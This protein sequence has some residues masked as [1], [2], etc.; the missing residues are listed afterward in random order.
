MAKEGATI[1][2]NFLH[3]TLE[4]GIDVGCQISVVIEIILKEKPIGINKHSPTY[5]RHS[6]VEE[7]YFSYTVGLAI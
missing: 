7:M 4:C 3:D 2:L 1:S 5:I 6:R